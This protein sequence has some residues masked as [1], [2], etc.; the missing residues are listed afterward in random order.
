MGMTI[1]VPDDVEPFVQRMVKSGAYADAAELVA[2]ALRRMSHD[3]DPSEW[4]T[5]P[6]EKARLSR[7][8][9]EGWESAKA[10][11]LISAEQLEK[12]MSDFKLRWKRERGIA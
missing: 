7:M 5:A 8:I 2:D 3:A 12:D 11:R 9:D 6:D 1:A 4:P 10:G